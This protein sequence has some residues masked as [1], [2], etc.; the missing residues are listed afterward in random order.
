M[1]A[2]FH[3]GLCKAQREIGFADAR[4]A[5]DLVHASLVEHTPLRGEAR[6]AWA[7]RFES[8]RDDLAEIDKQLPWIAL[9][10]GIHGAFRF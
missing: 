8:V 9:G 6:H 4:L 2:F 5:M 10:I 7:F 1:A 3:N